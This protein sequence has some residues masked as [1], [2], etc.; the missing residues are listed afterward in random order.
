ML[1]KHSRVVRPNAER[2]QTLA[3]QKGQTLVEFALVLPVLMLLVFGMLEFGRVL[4]TWLIVHNG[5]REG[6][7]YAAVGLSEGEVV[8]RV[9]EFCPSL[10]AASLVVEVTG[11][12]GPRGDPVTVRV[13]Y[14]VEITPLLQP[15]FTE[16]PYPVGAEAVMRLE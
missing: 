1:S 8:Q 10:D 5:A 4:S 11:A 12:Q 3:G 9:Q 2:D 16:H 6:A 13:T 14:A 7:R 15:L